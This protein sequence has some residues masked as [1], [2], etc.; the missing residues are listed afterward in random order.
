[1]LMHVPVFVALLHQLMGPADE[2]EPVKL[3]ELINHLAAVEPAGPPGAGLPGENIVRIAPHHIA[4][5]SIVR[6]LLV[7]INQ[8][9][10]INGAYIRG[11]ASVDAEHRILNQRS[12]GQ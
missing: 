9:D 6:N 12:N 11:K 3:V 4:K 7:P 5:G 10:L 2:L 1:M 8:P